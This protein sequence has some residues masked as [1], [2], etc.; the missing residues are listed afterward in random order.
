MKKH[1][2]L[3]ENHRTK[4]AIFYS[5]LLNYR[6]V[7]REVLKGPGL[8]S[9][10]VSGSFDGENDEQMPPKLASQ[11]SEFEVGFSS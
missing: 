6:R 2:F 8:W 4:W 1:Y 11:I 9:S 3:E 10:R 7:L 5:K